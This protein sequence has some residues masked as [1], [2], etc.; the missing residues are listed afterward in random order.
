[1][2]GSPSP[3]LAPDRLR[4]AIIGA[5]QHW[6][7][8]EAALAP[9]ALVV[10]DLHWADDTAVET[11]RRLT[12]SE[13]PPGLLV[14]MTVRTGEAPKALEHLL[15]DALELGPLTDAAA[16]EMVRSFASGASDLDDAAV[17]ALARRGEGVPLFT[18]HLVM[19]ARSQPS[20]AGM[21]ADALPA[22]LEGL[23]QVRLASS[24]PGRSVAEIAAVVGREFP[25][26]LA[27]RVLVELGENAPLPPTA[28]P[29]GLRALQRAG[30][31]EPSGEGTMRF[32]HSLVR[33]VAYELQLRTERPR[34]HAAAA[35]AIISMHGPSAAP[36]GL[37]YHFEQ[38]GDLE[39]AASAYLRAA[40]GAAGLAEFDISL[41][42]LRAAG[43]LDRADRGAGR[44]PVGAGPVHADRL[45]AGRVVQL[46]AATRASG[47]TSGRW[48]CATSSAPTRAPTSVSTCSSW[49]PSAGC[50]RRRWWPATCERRAA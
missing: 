24:G 15:E 16:V 21:A 32:R 23:L 43:A 49:P 5:L 1:M 50:G 14:L 46:R 33:D 19:A 27:E 36:E 17:E 11:L 34:R 37:A 9:V 41:E 35:R 7:A 38:A 13:L 8:V 22:T 25:V 30:L 6:V 48:S 18:E 31:V 29:A 45:R 3:E 2:P 10:E 44:S 42:H 12:A 4:E 26:D 40:E 47:P 28:L 20:P 39:A